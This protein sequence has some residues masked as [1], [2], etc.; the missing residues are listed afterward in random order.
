MAERVLAGADAVSVPV[1]YNVSGPQTFPSATSAWQNS[2]AGALL[3]RMSDGFPGPASADRRS[4]ALL[5][6]CVAVGLHR[7]TGADQVS[8]SVGAVHASHRRPVLVLRDL[9]YRVDG[10]L[11]RV[12]A[13][14][15][16]QHAGRGVRCVN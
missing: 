3:S 9:G 13:F 2:R 5:A 12:G 7:W 14:P 8:I 16:P 10:I 1:H 15:L 4:P 6:S 11:S